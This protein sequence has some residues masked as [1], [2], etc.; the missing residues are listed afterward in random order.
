MFKN[1]N[2]RP[3]V[4][5][6]LKWLDLMAFARRLLPH[7]EIVYLGYFTAPVD[8]QRSPAQASR[9]RAYLL[10][11]ESLE[12]VE[13]ILGYFR[14]VSHRG[15]QDPGGQPPKHI[16][17]HWKEKGSDVNLAM[18]MV[19]DACQHRYEKMLLISNDSDLVGTVRMIIHEMGV[20]VIV[21]SPG[22]TVGKALRNAATASFA[23]Q[24]DRLR[25]CEFPD[26]VTT[27]LGFTVTRPETWS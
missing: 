14:W 19:R 4:P 18:H 1:A 23:I 7:D 16:F 6:R 25:R 15:T 8:P 17:W 3:S 13:T 9:Q 5:N 20:P 24:P 11:L 12:G 27:K 2:R 21:A 10:A 26:V 22:T